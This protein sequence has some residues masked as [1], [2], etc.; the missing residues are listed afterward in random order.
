MVTL[1]DMEGNEA[2]EASSLGTA[3]V[4]EVRS[5]LTVR[6]ARAGTQ[7]SGIILT[8]VLE[9][10]CLTCCPTLAMQAG[11][12][13]ACAELIL[14]MHWPIVLWLCEHKKSSRCQSS[15]HQVQRQNVQCSCARC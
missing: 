6:A 14:C 4:V 2:F 12:G 10:G 8:A 13:R 1:A 3:E 7:G 15:L 5:R 9:S 11:V